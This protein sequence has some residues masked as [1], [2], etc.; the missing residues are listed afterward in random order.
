MGIYGTSCLFF[1]L[2]R[3]PVCRGLTIVSTFKLPPSKKLNL[4]GKNTPAV[5]HLHTMSDPWSSLDSDTS[6]DSAAVRTRM[7]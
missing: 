2:E 5:L 3:S 4:I 1:S 6:T 7:S